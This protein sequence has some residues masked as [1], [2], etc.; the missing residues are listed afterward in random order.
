MEKINER[1][2]L[3]KKFK[4]SL[5]YVDKH[6]YRKA[7][8]EVQK[9]IRT[10]KKAYFESKLTVDIT[11]PKELWK[12][13]DLKFE[14]SIFNINCLENDKSANFDARDIAKDFSAYFFKF[15]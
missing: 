13:L 4:K 5:L 11:K 2:K 12:S 6:S 10:K 15:G 8:N 7:R 9:L 1:D 3:F 14:S